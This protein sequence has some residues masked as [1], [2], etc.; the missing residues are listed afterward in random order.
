M[1]KQQGGGGGGGG[2]GDKPY[3]RREISRLKAQE[4]R[5]AYK[6]IMDDLTQVSSTMESC[7]EPPVTCEGLTSCFS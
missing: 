1:S 4:R 5:V 3:S 2:K 7:W 6:T